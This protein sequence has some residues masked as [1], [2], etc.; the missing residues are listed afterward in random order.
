MMNVCF[1]CGMYRA[2]KQIDPSGPFAICPECGYKHPFVW[3]PLL[4]VSGASGTG[5]TTICQRLLGKVTRAVLLDSDIL[6]RPEF[7]TPETNYRDYFELWLRICKNI[8]QSGRPVVLFGT[9]VGVPEN[10]EDLIER[11]YFSKIHYLALVCSDDV[12]AERLQQRPAW[13]GTQES[14]YIQA[15]IRFNRWFQEYDGQPITTLIETTTAPLEET[16]SQ[17]ESWIDEIIRVSN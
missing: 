1:Q 15:Q 10:L 13:R 6:W 4:I 12:L 7:N 16:A 11:R 17:V 5:K 2:D 9:G 8:A 3:S 14:A